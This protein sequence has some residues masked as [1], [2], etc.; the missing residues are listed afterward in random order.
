MRKLLLLLALLLSGAICAFAGPTE[1]TFVAWNNGDWQNGY[2]YIIEPTDGPTG[3][4]LAVMCDDYY[5][6]GQPGD[7][8]EANISSLGTGNISLARFNNLPGPNALYPLMLYDEA[9]W[10]LLETQVEPTNQW[11][12]IN[13]AVWY[14]FDP[15]Q[16]PCNGA[17]QMWVADAQSSIKGLPQSYYDDVY[18]I[19]PVNQH[20]PNPNDPQEFLALGT[21]SGLGIGGDTLQ[22][23]APEPGTL[24]LLG[25]GLVGIVGRKFLR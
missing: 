12:S 16:T 7:M 2:P 13:Y 14:I 4:I 20:D 23:S 15:S 6:G 8:W 1:F 17:C 9:G 21:P 19:T 25:S 10:L 18:I 5:H 24:V 11:Q 3:A 22:S